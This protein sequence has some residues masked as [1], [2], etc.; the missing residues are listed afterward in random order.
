M[1][2]AVNLDSG[3]RVKGRN[4]GGGAL[5]LWSKA[6]QMFGQ[7][8]KFEQR[9]KHTD[10]RCCA[11]VVSGSLRFIG[12]DALSLNGARIPRF[13]AWPQTIAGHR[14]CDPLLAVM[15]LHSPR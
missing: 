10:A 7:R 5:S 9:A 11:E 4:R 14:R 3:I 8:A 1:A 2:D 6:C 12:R 15:F 13:A